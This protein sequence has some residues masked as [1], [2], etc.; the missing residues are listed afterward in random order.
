MKTTIANCT[1]ILLLAFG[2][3]DDSSMGAGDAGPPDA[4]MELENPQ[5]QQGP[6]TRHGPCG[7][8]EELLVGTNEASRVTTF[9]YN[10]LG[11]ITSRQV[12]GAFPEVHIAFGLPDGVPDMTEAHKTDVKTG[13]ILETIVSFRPSLTSEGELEFVDGRTIRAVGSGE[14]IPVIR[15]GYDWSCWP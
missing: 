15:R 12:D 1:V 10:H 13:V 11:H 2:C 6:A 7:I 4:S 8:T 9:R 14:A 3:G 5:E